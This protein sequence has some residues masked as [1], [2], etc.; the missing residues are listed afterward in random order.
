M[1]RITFCILLLTIFLSQAAVLWRPF[2]GLEYEDAYVYTDT[3]RYMLADY[4]W[5][6]DRFKTK[7]VQDGS[8][9]H[10]YSFGTFGGHSEAFPLLIAIISSLISYHP[11][12][13]LLIN[14][15]L[16]YLIILLFVLRFRRLGLET[17]NVLLLCTASAPLLLLFQTSGTSETPSSLAL[18]VFLLTIDAAFLRS[19]QASRGWGLTAILALSLAIALK[20][21]NLV[22]LIAFPLL[23]T[24]HT[25][26][27]SRRDFYF[28]TACCSLFGLSYAAFFHIA[29]IENNEAQTIGAATF[30]LCNFQ[31]LFPALI[32]A[33]LRP[34]Y[35]GVMGLLFI[36]TPFLWRWIGNKTQFLLC[37]S[38][39]GGYILLYTFHYRNHYQVASGKISPF[40][41]MRYS[42]N[43]FPLILGAL[44]TVSWPTRQL[45]RSQVQLV[46]AALAVLLLPVNL[47]TRA[48]Y[49][50]IE[51]V[52][53]IEPANL[54]LKLARP[55]EPIVSEMSMV[56]RMLA[57][58]AQIL[59]DTQYVRSGRSS[60]N[61]SS[62]DTFLQVTS[63][64]STVTE[65]LAGS[66][67]GYSTTLIGETQHHLVLRF[68]KRPL[69]GDS[70]I[71]SESA[72]VDPNG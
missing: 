35:W 57:P 9:S 8:L 70:L 19:S 12:N 28:V 55:S 20:R 29:Q 61:R 25:P 37:A 2:W 36:I 63:R 33:L 3:A 24:F 68:Q 40:E 65:S 22:L 56:M 46:C 62:Y 7:S 26:V 27:R 58:D 17:V 1:A 67:Q 31:V 14:A 32:A 34:G 59:I 50:E 16:S 42:V 66:I 49:S 52:N 54:A 71:N 11:I 41:M 48:R 45:H 38:I 47:Y 72:S 60:L 43:L 18:A 69:R 53:R 13:A 30:S 64:D 51:R 15:V 23:W 5:S 21:E 4:P 39:C 10:V 44:S 6:V